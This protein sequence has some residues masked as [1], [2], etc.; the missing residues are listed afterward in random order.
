MTGHSNVSTQLLQ[1]NDGFLL[2]FAFDSYLDLSQSLFSQRLVIGDTSVSSSSFDAVS[3]FH[4]I[5]EM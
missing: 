3:Y 2:G 4:S 1:A 5:L